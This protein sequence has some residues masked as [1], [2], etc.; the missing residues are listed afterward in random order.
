VAKR[1]QKRPKFLA[2]QYVPSGRRDLGRP[3]QRWEDEERLIERI[4]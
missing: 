4:P 2:V 1:E 3:K